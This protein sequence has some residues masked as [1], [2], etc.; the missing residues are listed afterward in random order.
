MDYCEWKNGYRTEA[1][2][3]VARGLASKIAGIYTNVVRLQIKRWIGYDQTSYIKGIQQNDNTK[4]WLFAAFS[5]LPF[6][7]SFFGMIPMFFY[8]LT[9]KKRETMYADLLERRSN[10]SQNASDADEETM[11]RIAREQMEI[12]ITNKDKKL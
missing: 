2:T 8:D 10:M 12:G 3:S 9:G 7:T 1:M 5:I 6:A 11:A 4:Y